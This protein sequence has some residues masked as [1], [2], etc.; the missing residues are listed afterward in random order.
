MGAFRTTSQRV[1]TCGLR[2]GGSARLDDVG[3][4]VLEADGTQELSEG[5]S[6]LADMPELGGSNAENQEK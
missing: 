5:P 2:S 3:A 1:S 4:V 6:A